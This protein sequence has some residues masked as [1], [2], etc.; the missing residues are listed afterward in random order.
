MH[1]H[2]FKS[3]FPGGHDNEEL[4]VFSPAKSHNTDVCQLV[5]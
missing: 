1:A 4:Q 3:F 2:C 5:N